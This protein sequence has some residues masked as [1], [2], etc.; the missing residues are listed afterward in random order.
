MIGKLSTVIVAATTTT[1]LFFGAG[2]AAAYGEPGAAVTG[3]ATCGHDGD[4]IVVEI[5]API[6]YAQP[7]YLPGEHQQVR[8]RTVV[9][10]VLDELVGAGE[11]ETGKATA[12]DPADMDD[13]ELK[14][15]RNDPNSYRVIQEVEW[16]A[17][18]GKYVVAEA[19]LPA[20]SYLIKDGRTEL[21]TFDYCE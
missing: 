12:T 13:T 14:I 2:T 1:A 16:L 15:L 17:P 21:G 3:Q 9:F 11:W 6:V 5:D 20:T 10:D 7:D 18:D 8:Y 19:D 4:E